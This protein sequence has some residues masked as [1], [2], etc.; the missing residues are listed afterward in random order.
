M[1]E[2]ATQYGDDDKPI[3]FKVKGLA[4]PDV[5]RLYLQQARSPSKTPEEVLAADLR[6]AQVA[7][8]GWSANWKLDGKAVP[9][10]R[11]AVDKVFTIPA[12]RAAIL[13]QVTKERHFMNGA[14][15]QP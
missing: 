7:V 8:L 3:T 14:S 12:I 11:G 10:S 2:G 5:H 15:A 9:F 4:D 1:I 6:F 13:S